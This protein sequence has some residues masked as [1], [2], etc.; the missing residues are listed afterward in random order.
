MACGQCHQNP[1]KAAEGIFQITDWTTVS[2][3]TG[4][5]FAESIHKGVTNGSP[6]VPAGA[7]TPVCGPAAFVS[8]LLGDT[9]TPFTVS[10]LSTIN[11]GLA[12]TKTVY[13]DWG[14]GS[15][16]ENIDAGASSAPHT[17]TNPGYYKVRK[18]VQDSLGFSCYTEAE[19]AISN[20]AST[21]FGTFTVTANACV[22]GA[23]ITNVNVYL[24][25]GHL[26][27]HGVT[28]AAGTAAMPTIAGTMPNG[29]Y[30]MT[31]FGPQGLV[32]YTDAGCTT[33][34]NNPAT[35]GSTAET[36]T[37]TATVYCK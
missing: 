18:T 2:G 12:G 1:T 25:S 26:S 17:Y 29:S 4:T 30:N 7:G 9:S 37:G 33:P 24:V 3:T 20:L 23:P 32:C 35:G 13:I 22:G 28:N 27:F 10:D 36:V 19:V 21:G 5:S 31:A 8:P 34:V 16:M 15:G 6:V 11:G 14:D